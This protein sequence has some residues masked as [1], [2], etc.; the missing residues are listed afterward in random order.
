MTKFDTMMLAAAAAPAMFA[1]SAQAQVAGI[2]IANPE[3]AIRILWEV[4][5]QTKSTGKDEA[6][7]MR[8]D[9]ATLEARA[10]NWRYEPVGAKKWGENVEANYTAYMNWLA[11]QGVLKEKIATQDMITNDLIDEINSF[12]AAAV[13]AAAKAYK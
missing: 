6:T 7:A 5:P 8:D 11:E 1:A 13:V 9:L 3:A 10:R 4:Y 12:D 2:A